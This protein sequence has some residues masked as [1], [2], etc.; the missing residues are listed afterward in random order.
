MR[1]LI[2]LFRCYQSKPLAGSSPNPPAAALPT[3]YGGS[4]AAAGSRRMP[5]TTAATT[6]RQA[7]GRWGRAKSTSHPL[8]VGFV[9]ARSADVGA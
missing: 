8:R 5:T 1:R 7:G 2:L 9:L 6:T 4:R 3:F